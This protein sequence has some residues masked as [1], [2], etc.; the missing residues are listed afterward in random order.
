M[1]GKTFHA[2]SAALAVA[3][4]A[5]VLVACADAPAGPTPAVAATQP[6]LATFPD[7]GTCTQLQVDEGSTVAMH[8]YAQGVQIYHWSGTAWQF[9][10]PS[11]TL[12]ADAGMTGVIA[13]HFGGPRWK[14]NGGSVVKGGTLVD[15]CIPDAASIPW[16]ELTATTE[17]PGIFDGVTRIQRLFTVGGNAPATPGSFVGE[18]T[19]VPYTA[20][21]YF[22]R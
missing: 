18:V 3:F 16:L 6:R 14:H 9:D 13:T 10:A 7:L 11:A 21:Y 2:L 5:V 22:Y 17:V 20:E 15:R 12:Y 8:A 1:N 19:K 4:T